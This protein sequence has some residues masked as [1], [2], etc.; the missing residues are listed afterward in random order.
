MGFAPSS[1]LPPSHSRKL[2]WEQTEASGQVRRASDSKEGAGQ[3]YCF[4][5]VPA[6]EALPSLPPSGAA[7]GTLPDL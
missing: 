4:F 6:E 3:N 7:A 2:P 5:P 1:N